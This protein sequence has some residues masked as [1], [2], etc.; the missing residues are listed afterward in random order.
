M[1]RSRVT[2][3]PGQQP[4]PE[5]ER[6]RRRRL[7]FVC[8]GPIYIALNGT[9]AADITT[10]GEWYGRME[11]GII[12][13]MARPTKWTLTN[14]KKCRAGKWPSAGRRAFRVPRQ[15][16]Y[17]EHSSIWHGAANWVFLHRNA[18]KSNAAPMKKLEI[19]IAMSFRAL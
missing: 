5:A 16:T 17:P 11:Q 1:P 2:V 7:P 10:A 6:A 15:R 19:P 18:L 9:G 3:T 4:V 13:L 14:R 8:N 12:S